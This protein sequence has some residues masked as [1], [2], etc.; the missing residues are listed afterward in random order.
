MNDKDMTYVRHSICHTFTYLHMGQN[1]S[2][3]IIFT[4]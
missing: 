4:D 2:S 3:D 1:S